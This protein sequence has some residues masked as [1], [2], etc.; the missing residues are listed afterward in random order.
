MMSTIHP[1]VRFAACVGLAAAA[2][3]CSAAPQPTL[4]SNVPG[5]IAALGD[6]SF[7]RPLE[8]LSKE[9]L[10]AYHRGRTLFD[11]NFTPAEG[12]GPLFNNTS[13]KACHGWP[14]SGGGSAEL[15]TIIGATDAGGAPRTLKEKGGPVIS[16]HAIMGTPREQFPLGTQAISKR[17]SPP[18]F[19]TGLIEAIPADDITARLAASP[20]REALGIHGRTNVDGGALGRLGWKAQTADML[21]FTVTASN[22][23]MGLSSSQRPYE[24]FANMP[25]QQLASPAAY[26]SVGFVKDYF[27]QRGEAGRKP[28]LTD[29]QVKD[30]TAFQRYQAPPSPLPFT[31]QAKVGQ[32]SFE[33]IG[34]AECHVPAMVTGAN[35]IGIPAGVNVPLYSDLL[36]HD[37]GEALSDGIAWQ[38]RAKGPDWRTVPLWGLRYKQRYMHDGRTNSLEE[39]IQLHGGEGA[40]TVAGYNGLDAAT[41]EALRAFLLSL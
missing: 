16:D 7:V 40:Q 34:C 21:S 24:F 13:C 22:F 35:A 23:E 15:L 2:I 25:P 36:L 11:K 8:G 5:A 18:T 33:R 4:V 3:G 17:T 30:L 39:A 41:R 20:R 12:L 28:D 37:M 1:R 14:N 38:G 10:E 32:A 9:H 26:P 31:P 19:G 27:D 6:E 29:E